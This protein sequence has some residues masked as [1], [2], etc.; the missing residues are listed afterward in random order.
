M[1]WTFINHSMAAVLCL[2][3]LPIPIDQSNRKAKVDT[4]QSYCN[5]CSSSRAA[6]IKTCKIMLSTCHTLE[7]ILRCIIENTKIQMHYTVDIHWP[8]EISDKTR[9]PGRVSISCWDLNF[10]NEHKC[11]NGK[12]W[13]STV[14][15]L[16]GATSP[17][18]VHARFS[19]F[20]KFSMHVSPT[21]RSWP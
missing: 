21:F 14:N 5:T 13:E 4:Q 9:C 17:G 20:W 10:H 16:Y 7:C 6:F 11:P 12:A 18:T 2:C 15:M 8:R 1:C 3:K 19:H